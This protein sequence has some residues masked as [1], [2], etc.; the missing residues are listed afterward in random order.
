MGLRK[1]GAITVR[2]GVDF[3]D[4]RVFLRPGRHDRP[5]EDR[6]SSLPPQSAC[7]TRS[8]GKV[9]VTVVPDPR[10]LLIF[11]VPPWASTMR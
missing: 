1:N 11:V 4:G 3:G 8:G 10:W 7:E 6:A 9:T 2:C 5:L